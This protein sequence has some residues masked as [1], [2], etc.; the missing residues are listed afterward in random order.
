MVRVRA[1]NLVVCPVHSNGSAKVQPIAQSG[2]VH[3]FRE[4]L[5]MGWKFSCLEGHLRCETGVS[6]GRFWEKVFPPWM[7][8]RFH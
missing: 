6:S 7:A 1:T 3:G 2:Q 8:K 5:G 4:F